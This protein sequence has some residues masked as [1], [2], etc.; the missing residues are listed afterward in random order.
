MIDKN[1]LGYK[2]VS[3]NEITLSILDKKYDDKNDDS[4][5]FRA[6]LLHYEAKNALDIV[7]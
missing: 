3:D 6:I 2:I 7:L 1:K 4:I 5:K